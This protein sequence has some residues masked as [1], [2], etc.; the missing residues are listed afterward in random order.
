MS[1]NYLLQSGLLIIVVLGLIVL[2]AVRLSRP[3]AAADAKN[4]AGH[5][6]E[7]TSSSFKEGQ[8]MPRQL[9][10]DGKDLSPALAWA[11]PPERTKSIALICDDPD[12]PAGTW[13]HWVIYDIPAT[14]RALAE[15]VPASKTLNDGSKQGTNSFGK[16]GYGGPSPPPGKPHHYIFK[17][18]ALD[19]AVALEPGAKKAQLVEAMKGH[20]IAETSL[21]GLYGR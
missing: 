12:A 11:A 13:V 16:I 3:A 7:L 6:W 17:L 20:I 1:N 8:T 2:L 5:K 14:G 19:A 15:G 10:A 9:T 18:Y 4:A 21:T